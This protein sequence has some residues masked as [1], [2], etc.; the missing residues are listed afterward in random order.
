MQLV[1]FAIR[2]D[3][4]DICAPI[5]NFLYRPEEKEVQEFVDEVEKFWNGFAEHVLIIKS[6]LNQSEEQ[7]L[8]SGFRNKDGG[9]LLFRPIAL[10]QFM[11]AAMEYKK[12][13]G[14]SIEESFQRLSGIPLVIQEKPWK[15]VL[16]LEERKNIHGRI[17]KKELM[18]M[19]LFLADESLLQAEEIDLVINYLLALRDMDQTGYGDMLEQL[20]ELQVKC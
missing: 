2:N 16:W 15:N 6:Y 7:V 9:N 3:N 13:K 14:T 11:I 1:I 17:R 5:F 10:S 12:R 19:M 4:S 20:R 8:K 18:L